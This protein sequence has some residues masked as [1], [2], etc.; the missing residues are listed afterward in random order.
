MDSDGHRTIGHFQ[1]YSD[2]FRCE[3][4]RTKFKLSQ[5]KAWRYG[6]TMLSLHSQ[7]HAK[8][9]CLPINLSIIFPACTVDGFRRRQ[10]HSHFQITRDLSGYTI[11]KSEGSRTPD[12]SAGVA[13][14]VPYKDVNEKLL[15]S[16]PS[17][18]HRQSSR[19][20][21]AGNAAGGGPHTVRWRSICGW[22][23]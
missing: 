17:L 4:K 11:R 10:F 19:Y 5:R 9:G 8:C 23:E 2:G 1:L 12:G 22:G 3:W 6:R 13:H 21:Q 20:V 16:K 14:Q 18:E 7:F 15:P